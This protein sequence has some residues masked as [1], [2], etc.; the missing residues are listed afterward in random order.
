[1]LYKSESLSKSLFDTFYD[2]YK[3]LGAKLYKFRQTVIQKHNIFN[4]D[5]EE[6]I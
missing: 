5:P 6:T 1:M 4:A 2:R 3:E